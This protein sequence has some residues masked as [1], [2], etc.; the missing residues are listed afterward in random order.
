[1]FLAIAER[2]KMMNAET[3]QTVASLLVLLLAEKV[4]I[5]ENKC[6]SYIVIKNPA[7]TQRFGTLYKKFAGWAKSFTLPNIFLS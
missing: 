7:G 5:A 6:N 4:A 2:L 3:I 1:M